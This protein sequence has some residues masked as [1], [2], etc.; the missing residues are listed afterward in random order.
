M[1]NY[2]IWED[3]EGLDERMWYPTRKAAEQDVI[4]QASELVESEGLDS[5]EA[6]ERFEILDDAQK[7]TRL[8]EVEAVE[9]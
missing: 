1:T 4:R 9:I 5:E 8:A 3:G 7:A 2:W 6:M